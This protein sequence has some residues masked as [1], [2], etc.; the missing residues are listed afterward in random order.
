[1]YLIKLA[2]TSYK[3][4]VVKIEKRKTEH[5]SVPKTQTFRNLLPGEF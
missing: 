5:A 4:D 1:M 2:S 3:M